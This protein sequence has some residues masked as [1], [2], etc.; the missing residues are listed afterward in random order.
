[1]IARPRMARITP[2]F[3]GFPAVPNDSLFF[4]DDFSP[5]IM[6]LAQKQRLR[7]PLKQ[8]FGYAFWVLV[9]KE[10]LTLQ[11][12]LYYTSSVTYGT[13]T[14]CIIHTPTHIHSELVRRQART[15][16]EA[17]T[18]TCARLHSAA[19]L[20]HSTKPELD[21]VSPNLF[22]TTVVLLSSRK[23]A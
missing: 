2:A 15:G 23:S 20:K 13:V 17:G 12:Q 22:D 6:G 19:L 18:N 3:S 5:V 21:V 1:M 4:G 9:R 7:D 10:A 16:G 11:I 8:L 14:P